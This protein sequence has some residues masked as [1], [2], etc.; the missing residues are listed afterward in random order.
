MRK[1]RDS[2]MTLRTKVHDMIVGKKTKAEIEK[3]LRTDFKFA[4][5]HIERSL[6]GLMLELQ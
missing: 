5:L 3:M 2:T 1:F 6:D 4:D